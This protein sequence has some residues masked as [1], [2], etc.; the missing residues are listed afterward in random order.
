MTSILRRAS[1]LSPYRLD[2][3]DDL[4]PLELGMPE[5]ERSVLAGALMREAEALRPRPCFEIGLASPDRV[6]RVEH[7]VFPFRPAQQVK[8]HKAGDVAQVGVARC[9]HTLELGLRRGNDFEP[10]HR[11][12][13]FALLLAAY[14]LLSRFHFRALPRG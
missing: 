5:I 4:K 8:L 14:T 7:M 6:R 3:L 13:H 9:P 1:V 2:C 12:E 11:D 10:I